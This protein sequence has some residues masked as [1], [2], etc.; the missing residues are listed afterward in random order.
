MTPE[1]A[2]CAWV[3]HILWEAAAP[4]NDGRSNAAQQNPAYGLS[5]GGKGGT[6]TVPPAHRLPAQT[7]AWCPVRAMGRPRT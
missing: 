6:C 7:I 1:R 2:A 5:W 3:R 4:S